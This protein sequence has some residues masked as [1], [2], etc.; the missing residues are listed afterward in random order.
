MQR[1][2]TGRSTGLWLRAAEAGAHR[3]EPTGRPARGPHLRAVPEHPSVTRLLVGAPGEP[4]PPVDRLAAFVRSLRPATRS[5][6][7]V[8]VYGPEPEDDVS[9]AQRLADELGEPLQARHGLVLGDERETAATTVV[10]ADSRPTWQPFA[11]VSTY[12]PGGSGAEVTRWRR[13]AAHLAP[14]GPHLYELSDDWVVDVVP[15]GLVVRQAT[16]VTEPWAAAPPAHADRVDLFI[17]LRDLR[18]RPDGMLAALGRFADSLPRPARTRLRVVR[19][20]DCPDRVSQALRW[21]VPAPQHAG[22]FTIA[23]LETASPA[24]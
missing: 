7:R 16:A 2:T 11:C 14:A 18:R 19:P 8:L 12:R 4:L 1:K 3:G 6:L 24:A 17:D 5:S 23:G 20:G 10:G 13:P 21:A 22:D 9:L 15:A